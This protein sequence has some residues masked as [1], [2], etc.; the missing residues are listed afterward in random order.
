M[1]KRLAKILRA[2]VYGFVG[3]F[4]AYILSGSD[5]SGPLGLLIAYLEYRFK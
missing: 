2:L 3:G 4:V 5:V 1:D